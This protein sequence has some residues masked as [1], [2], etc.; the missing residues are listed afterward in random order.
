MPRQNS[1]GGKPALGAITKQRNRYIRKLL[2]LSAT[3]LLHG[4]GKRK[5]ALRDWI[6]ALLARKPARLV[7]VALANKL[8]R[9]VWAM[10]KSGECFRADS[11]A[12]A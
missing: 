11:F 1:T 7:T 3:S 2:V 8:A 9:I 12:K 6:L 5:G 4:V 10:M